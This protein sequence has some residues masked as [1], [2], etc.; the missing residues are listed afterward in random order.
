MREFQ[1]MFHLVEPHALPYEVSTYIYIYIYIIFLLKKIIKNTFNVYD[2]VNEL[3]VLHKCK[4]WWDGSLNER[5]SKNVP[6]GK[7]SYSHIWDFFFI[8]ITINSFR[9]LVHLFN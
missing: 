3:K 1:G 4:L 6:L 8:Y 5:V 2:T 9:S 7:T